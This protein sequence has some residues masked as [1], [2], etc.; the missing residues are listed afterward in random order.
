MINDNTRTVIF[1]L[2]FVFG[3]GWV[4]LAW[5]TGPVRDIGT[6]VISRIDKC[7]ETAPR[8]VHCEYE[9]TTKEVVTDKEHPPIR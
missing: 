5:Y 9:I 3:A 6:E 7:Q 2:G 4:Y 8:N 1:M